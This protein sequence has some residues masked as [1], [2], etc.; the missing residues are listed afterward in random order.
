MANQSQSQRVQP[1]NP[2]LSPKNPES[3]ASAEIVNLTIG[4]PRAWNPI[5]E[6]AASHGIAIDLALIVNSTCIQHKPD[7]LGQIIDCIANEEALNILRSW[8]SHS[9]AASVL[10]RFTEVAYLN[11]PPL[12]GAI[13]KLTPS[14][15]MFHGT[16]ETHYLLA[17]ISE[18]TPKVDAA[19][20]DWLI[21]LRLWTIVQGLTRSLRQNV[22]DQ[23]LRTVASKLRIAFDTE[24]YWR[25]LY[26]VT[27]K[28]DAS[29]LDEISRFLIYKAE[30]LLA[31]KDAPL[32]SV[33]RQ[34]L[35]ALVSVARQEDHRD[36]SQQPV[37][38]QLSIDSLSA[39]LHFHAL[40]AWKI[41]DEEH[42]SN[43]EYFPVDEGIGSDLVLT[44]V[45]P[46]R[47][48]T[49][50]VLQGNSILL[51]AVEQLQYLPWSWSHINPRETENL[52]AWLNRSIS[53]AMPHQRCLAFYIWSGLNL[54]RSL[55]RVLDIALSN[56]IEYDWTLDTDSLEYR[57]L[58]P[59]RTPGWKPSTNSDSEW[60]VPPAPAQFIQLPEAF[61]AL[62]KD[63]LAATKS[64][65]QCIGHLWDSSWDPIEQ[66]FTSEME[67]I[68]PRVRS[69]MLASALP[70]RSFSS[71]EDH[72]F[73]RLL[74]SSPT[75]ALQGAC[76]Y[77]SW[78]SQQVAPLLGNDVNKQSDAD[79]AMGSLL[80]PI[81]ALLTSEIKR[82]SKALDEL[83]VCNDLVRFHNCF[84]AYV[85]VAYLAATG[86]RPIRDPIEA[87]SQIDPEL[88][89]SF[90][91]DKASSDLHQGRLVPLP[92]MIC[93]L[94]YEDYPAHLRLLSSHLRLLHPHLARNIDIL[95][96]ENG[97]ASLPLMFFLNED[98]SRWLSVSEDSIRKLDLFGWPLPLNHFRHRLARQLRKLSVD[99]ETIDSIL[100][101]VEAGSATHGDYS[102]RIWKDDIKTARPSIEAA[103]ESLGFIRMLPW[104]GSNANIPK[105]KDI[106]KSDIPIISFGAAARE[107]ERRR[108]LR[109]I[110]KD[111]NIQIDNFLGG[112]TISELIDQEVETLSRQLLMLP[113]QL[114][115]PSG[116]RKY[117]IFLKR[118]ERE[119]K[120]T[121]K[122]VRM[123][124]RYRSMSPEQSMFSQLAPRAHRV[125]QK[126]SAL[127]QSIPTNNIGRI[128][129]Q[130]RA[131]IAATLLCFDNR[132]AD[133]K[134][135]DDILH[136]R[137]FRIVSMK[138]TPY[139][140]YAKGLTPDHA[141][142]PCRR[143]KLSHRVATYL[144]RLLE[145]NR[146]IVPGEVPRYLS[147]LSEAMLEMMPGVEH[148]NSSK[149]LISLI[150]KIVDQVNAM[151][152]PGV[153]AGYLGGRVETYSLP[154]RNWASQTLG[155]PISIPK[156]EGNNELDEGDL[157]ARLH[158]F[159]ST[160]AA[161][162]PVRPSEIDNLLINAYS[163]LKEIEKELPRE[164]KSDKATGKVKR[165]DVARKIQDVIDRHDGKVSSAIL[166]LGRWAIVLLYRR[167]RDGFIQLSTIFRYLS[168]LKT[169]FLESAYAADILGMDYEE[170]TTLYSQVLESSQAE[171]KKYVADRLYDFHRFARREFAIED[172]DWQELPEI[173]AVAHVA[174]GVIS[175]RDYLSALQLLLKAP[176]SALL[177]RDAPA[178]LLMLC[179]RFGLRGSEGLGLLRSDIELYEDFM[180]V[181]VCSN[182]YRRLKTKSSR[183]QN[184]LL[185][186]LSKTEW[187]LLGR[188]LAD[189]DARHGCDYSMPIFHDPT[190]STLLLK[191]STITKRIIDVLKIATS[192]IDITL[193]HARHSAAHSLCLS[194]LYYD[195]LCVA[196]TA[197]V[198]SYAIQNA[199]II[200]LGKV[201]KT[202]RKLWAAARFLGH[203]RRETTLR[204]YI[205]FIGELSDQY[206]VTA[207]ES[208]LIK[209][210]HAIC[211]DEFPRLAP[212]DSSLIAE[213]KDADVPQTPTLLL[214]LMR[215]ISRGQSVE[216]AAEALSVN[217]NLAVKLLN[218]LSLIGGKAKLGSTKLS[219][220]QDNVRPELRLLQRIKESAW[221]R[222]INYA[223]SLEKNDG[224]KPNLAA[225]KSE[226]SDYADMIGIT[227][228][229]LMWEEEHFKLIASFVDHF[230]LQP[231]S[232]VVV[233]SCKDKNLEHLIEKHGF[234]AI[235]REETSV[236]NKFQLDTAL[237][238][239]GRYSVRSRC[240][241]VV[242]QSNTEPIRNRIELAVCLAAFLLSV[243]PH[244]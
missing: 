218:L 213:L 230:E 234:R 118:I 229:V 130:D 49:H 138:G 4:L 128:S 219:T 194:L 177:P 235:N 115:H 170:I 84:T 87:L 85:A 45:D 211:I 204:S 199:E 116:H 191:Q 187:A 184:P 148:P 242:K 94:L 236:S 11:P 70:L 200:L 113:N 206:V 240:S 13:T 103:F 212:V 26:C 38:A 119:W 133:L 129:L 195:K 209:L 197:E 73:T 14:R 63:R 9:E 112:R 216:A 35:R 68:A 243:A 59:R 52:A 232:Y 20:H 99:A 22:Q 120:K 75:T 156:P 110:I 40:P 102:F 51:Y 159:I 126:L 32:S 134:L 144:D 185:F 1:S 188:V 131:A 95:L 50:Q 37:P 226:V 135:L 8:S 79:N 28:C 224:F 12:Q 167:S 165:R 97:P 88:K 114:P 18:R 141:D 33:S 83:R 154:W 54:G 222:I 168:A 175:E 210:N 100:G 164:D 82:T 153:L 198:Q 190:S 5:F 169:G 48:A 192:N 23:M 17:L 93:H 117:Q 89:A 158:E 142:V 92:A 140:E 66:V 60:I 10:L 69:S 96:E 78:S 25:T 207:H 76:A 145:R 91:L 132:I 47:S 180:I 201:G 36:Y 86:A 171:D 237:I 42:E 203:A 137:N 149:G 55:R 104:A 57:R 181:L 150:A 109:A 65:H 44:L 147:A 244:G 136:A 34:L 127:A 24:N 186:K 111:A 27:L 215:L 15:V 43:G 202:R 2:D 64:R 163:F 125:F 53:S 6:W 152:M 106:S 161:H 105:A 56:E 231:A 98:C 214:K 139:L 121:G 101:H 41:D 239:G 228:Q 155:Y 71:T 208:E 176:S 193:H 81:E 183:R 223:A 46:S 30:W 16:L 162:S 74:A 107:K 151:N 227:Q 58:P 77:A 241:L 221:N 7:D 62:V 173:L 123:S 205:H 3:P 108:S 220:R 31:Q 174:P 182:K 29:D 189:Y 67:A 124:K 166:L 179:F 146:S 217:Q 225:N 61:H 160:S 157:N 196:N 80:D 90:V 72:V 21:H 178:F 172:P 238:E 233:R 39:E 143:F 122:R 19:K